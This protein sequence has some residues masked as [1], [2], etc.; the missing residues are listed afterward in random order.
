MLI[1]HTHK[2]VFINT[3]FTGCDQLVDALS[4]YSDVLGNHDRTS[5]FYAH[6]TPVK[7]KSYFKTQ[8]WNW[9]DYFKFAV[10]RNPWERVVY[11]HF[12]LQPSDEFD[13]RVEYKLPYVNRQHWW[14]D[15]DGE[16]LVNLVCR[17]EN[18]QND[19]DFVCD[20][21]G[22]PKKRLK[23]FKTIRTKH[24]SEYYESEHLV[25]KVSETCIDDIK[26]FGYR[27]E[28][29]Q[30]SK[31]PNK[32]LTTSDAPHK[33]PDFIIPGFQ[34][35]G[36][37]ALW[38]NLNKHPQLSM[39][40]KKE[41]N[42]FSDTETHNRGN[43]WYAGHFK[44]DGN[45]WGDASPNYL[46]REEKYVE[47]MKDV[48]PDVKFIVSIRNPIDRAYSAY[49]HYMQNLSKSRKHTGWLRPGESFDE[50]ISAEESLGFV[51]GM[52]GMGFYV[53]KLKY[54]L[55][56]YNRN[57]IHIVIQEKMYVNPEEIYNEIFSFLDVK[58]KQLVYGYS[59]RRK[60]DE[61]IGEYCKERLSA[62]YAPYNERLFE[63]LGYEIDEWK[64]S[65]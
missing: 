57:Q 21:I 18:L 40:G 30:L 47:R 10:V 61:P 60:Y 58:P 62:I 64:V 29:I 63:F 39:A 16:Q 44:N 43:G 27:F 52:V 28:R 5:P 19:F 33:L 34:K 55:K 32:K 54:L 23:I 37:T 25:N 9:N 3:P 35:C 6:T 49:N 48:I 1:S 38:T 20:K 7:L 12:E 22:I 53:D 8:S 65:Q 24:Y 13:E 46:D 51:K 17:Y 59:H 31:S 42:F 50:N 26:R 15:T 4:G 41:I 56:Y 45:L 2:F 11:R 14:V 36:T